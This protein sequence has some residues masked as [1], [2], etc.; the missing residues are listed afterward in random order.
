M[1]RERWAALV[2]ILGSG[3]A[4]VS[5][6]GEAPTGGGRPLEGGAVR[7]GV[8]T[9]YEA[10][11][12]GACSF[13]PSDDLDVAALNAEEWAGSANCGVC[14][15]VRGPDGSVR[16]RIVDLCPECLAGHLDL[17][18]SAFAKVARPELGRVDVEWEL[19]SCDVAGPMRYKYKD[20]SNEWWTAVQIRNHRVPIAAVAFSVDGET[21]VD[22]ERTDYNYFLT[23]SG[24][25]A[26]PVVLRI[27]GSNGE[28]V[29]EE[30]PAVQDS[31]EIAGTK[32]FE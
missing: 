22:L 13:D 26:A 11:G 8:I 4:A 25:G 17:S 9:Y 30:L 6:G 27:T 16:V 19:T 23:E 31:L 2:G 18:A 1:E 15:D 5:C 32:Q 21:F 28:V 12:A 10:T 3:V 20:G 14:V 7:E 29:E 24:F